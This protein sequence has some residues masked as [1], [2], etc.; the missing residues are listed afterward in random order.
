M[1]AYIHTY[2]YTN[3]TH[4]CKYVIKYICILTEWENV[5]PLNQHFKYENFL[6]VAKNVPRR[7]SGTIKIHIR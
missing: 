6:L 5:F 3:H 2:V 4:T 1:Y 7:F